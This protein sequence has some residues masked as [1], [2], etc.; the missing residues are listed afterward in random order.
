MSGEGGSSE[1]TLQAELSRR[2]DLEEVSKCIGGA[3]LGWGAYLRGLMAVGCAAF[4]VLE[5]IQL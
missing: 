5:G 4:L 1:E 3:Q 2:W